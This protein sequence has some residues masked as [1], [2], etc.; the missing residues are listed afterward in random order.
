MRATLSLRAHI[1]LHALV[2]TPR[3][4]KTIGIRHC[5]RPSARKRN[6]LYR[7]SIECR[8][9]IVNEAS[10]LFQVVATAHNHRHIV[11]LSRIRSNRELVS[12][13][14][15]NRTAQRFHW[16]RNSVTA[17][18]TDLTHA[19]I[20]KTK[21]SSL[22]IDVSQRSHTV[23][24]ASSDRQPRRQARWFDNANERSFVYSV[25]A[26]KLATSVLSESPQTVPLDIGIV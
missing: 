22:T 11:A 7:A 18:I 20:A 12:T 9:A 6:A 21:R 10:T 16:F 19:I 15:S 14:N 5:V 25:A 4:C 8:R 13:S 24:G 26:A 17:L 23:C 3:V 2:R 1:A